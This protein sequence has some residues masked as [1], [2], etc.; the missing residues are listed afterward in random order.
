VA[1]GTAE[2]LPGLLDW[3]EWGGVALDL[4]ALGPG[5]RMRAPWPC[6]PDSAYGSSVYGPSAS[7]RGRCGH[8]PSEQGPASSREAADG[9]T[10]PVWLRPPE[11]GCEVEPTLPATTV[12]GGCRGGGD[13]DCAPDLARLVGA[14]ATE[15]H[16]TRLLRATSAQAL[17]FSYASRT[18]AGTRPRSLTS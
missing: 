2:E 10:Q 5:G 12:L 1:A 4:A 13:S 7:A 3:L 17:A 14:V 11:P 18:V 15:C 8:G 16:R 6:L 9:R